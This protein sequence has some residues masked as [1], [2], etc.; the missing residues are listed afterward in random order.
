ML[1]FI[2]KVQLRLAQNNAADFE[3]QSTVS[4]NQ[5]QSYACTICITIICTVVPQK[6]F[7]QKTGS[8]NSHFIAKDIKSIIF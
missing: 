3:T 8:L 7:C 5:H 4:S 6:K 2:S 1:V